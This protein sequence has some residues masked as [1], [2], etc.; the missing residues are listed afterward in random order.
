[1]DTSDDKQL[2]PSSNQVEENRAMPELPDDALIILPVRNVVLFPGVVLPLTLGRG[3]SIAAAQEAARSDRPVGVLLQRDSEVETPQPEDLYEMG[4]VGSI[5]RYVTGPDRTHHLI[6]QGERRFRVKEFL[7][8]YPFLVARV[9]QIGVKEVYSTEVEARYRKLRERALEA[10]K[11]FPQAPPQLGQAIAEIRSP[12]ALADLIASFMD[13]EPADK[14]A[15][16][17]LEDVEQRLDRVL[18]LVA[19]GIEVMRLTQEIGERTKETLDERQR[20]YL[21][22]EQM[23]TIQKELG[24][25]EGQGAEI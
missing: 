1:M 7:E 2:I 9:E 22:R 8:G 25:L 12:S 23:R 10:L 4:C 19:R 14:Q 13:I 6:C 11:F 3:P 15:V 5:L 17:E 21:L 24:E 20:E 18:E 16:L